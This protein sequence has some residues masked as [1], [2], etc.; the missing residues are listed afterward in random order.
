MFTISE[1]AFENNTTT[2]GLKIKAQFI[3][4]YSVFSL[5]F[6]VDPYFM[7]KP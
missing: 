1:A 7:T 5:K 3:P 4:A 2:M 6:F